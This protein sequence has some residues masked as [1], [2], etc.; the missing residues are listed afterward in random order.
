MDR[1]RRATAIINVLAFWYSFCEDNTDM[2]G[3]KKRVILSFTIFAMFFG[4][5]NLIFPPFLAY[6]AGEN[7]GIAFLGFV[8]TAIGLPVLSL[9]AISRAGS[10]EKLAGRVHPAFGIIFTVAI[11]LAIGPCLAIPR[12]ASTSY[13]MLVKAY[14]FDSMASRLIYS[15]IFFFLSSLIALR[16]EKLTRRLGRI[17]SPALVLLIV[18]LFVFSLSVPYDSNMPAKDAYSESAFQTGFTDGYQT[19]DALAGL[20]FGII[21]SINV[22]AI[23]TEKGKERREEAIAAIGGGI[24]LLAIYLMIVSVGL[25][26]RSFSS[27]ASNGAEVLSEMAYHVSGS[28]GRPILAL[29]FIIACFNTSVGLLSSC[30]EFFTRLYSRISRTAWIFI[31]A[32]FSFLISNIGLDAIIRV[33]SPILTLLYPAA[34]T[35]IGLSFI[36][37][38]DK[39]HCTYVFSVTLALLFSLLTILKLFSSPFIWLPPAI[40]GGIAGYLLD[41]KKSLKQ[42]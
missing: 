27:D 10:A 25:S 22:K 32:F 37:D 23:G 34:I 1:I 41:R 15:A 33:S 11:Y 2:T 3:L 21:L 12:T 7:A 31:F 9:I 42:G 17:L 16:P 18:I 20:V 6:K 19:M 28:F 40:I 29:I 5:G 4:A 13:E 14:P 38:T 30:G 24:L 39:L 35:L 8:I 36:K 26:A